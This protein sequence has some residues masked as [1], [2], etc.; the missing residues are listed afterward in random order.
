MYVFW[1]YAVWTGKQP[2]FG[3]AYY[4]HRQGSPKRGDIL[5]GLR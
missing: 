2:H 5:L 4:L 3:G 1:D